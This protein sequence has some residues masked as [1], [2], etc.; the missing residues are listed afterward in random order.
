VRR[1]VARDVAHQ[2]EAVRDAAR[3]AD[4]ILGAG[5]MWAAASVAEAYKLP[6]WYLAYAPEAIASAHYPPMFVPFGGLPRFVN[7]LAWKV[8]G[9]LVESI[10]R[11][12]VNRQRALLALAPADAAIPLTFAEPRA[13]L[14]TDSELA[15][16]PADLRGAGPASGWLSLPDHRELG[17]SLQAFLD[18][19][20]PPVYFGFGSMV[21]RNPA[22]ITKIVVDAARAVGR[23][24]LIS[25]GWA[26]LGSIESLD[27]DTLVIGSVPHAKLFPR[28]AAVVHHGG[29]GTTHAAAR[30]GV[31]Q[32]VV[33]HL[34]DQ[35]CWAR[36]VAQLGLG[37]KP[38]PRWQLS[39]SRLT[40]RLEACLSDPA[41]APR[42]SD[43]ARQIG[44]RDGVANLVRFLEHQIGGSHRSARPASSRSRPAPGV[45]QSGNSR[46]SPLL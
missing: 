1:D 25:A 39:P 24:A 30:A 33:P 35:F 15:S 27:S 45:S 20:P 3:G 8:F 6:Y 10:V 13:V 21:D 23:R 42:A 22:R 16:W 14:A 26:G 29:A 46:P 9:S 36:R 31:P 12:P 44:S 4:A 5:I 7:R 2:F 32:I 40:A 17:P 43:L 11:E 38:L 37:P 18:A 34:L 41:I 19:G 28:V